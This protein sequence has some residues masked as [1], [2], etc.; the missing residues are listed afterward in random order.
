MVYVSPRNFRVLMVL[1]T[2]GI[3]YRVGFEFIFGR[4]FGKFCTFVAI[5]EI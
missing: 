5:I 4:G 1:V 3:W 2:I